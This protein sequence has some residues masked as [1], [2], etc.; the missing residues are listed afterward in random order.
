[1]SLSPFDQRQQ[2]GFDQI[3]LRN[4]QSRKIKRG[5][6]RTFIVTEFELFYDFPGVVMDQKKLTILFEKAVSQ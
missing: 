3:M 1:M 2:F 4:V 5:Y 6:L